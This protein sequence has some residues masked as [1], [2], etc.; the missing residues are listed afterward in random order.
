[1]AVKYSL[2]QFLKSYIAA[3]DKAVCMYSQKQIDDAKYDKPCCSYENQIK[4]G[5]FLK[6]CLENIDCFS[7][8]EQDKL[9]SVS[10]RFSQNCGGCVV[11]DAELAAFKLTPKGKELIEEFL[12][13]DVKKY[14]NKSGVSDGVII[15]RVNTYVTEL[16]AAGLWSKFYAIY[17]FLGGTASTSSY[18][19]KDADYYQ[20]SWAGGMSYGTLGVDFNGTSGFGDTNFDFS[21]ISSSIENIHISFYTADANGGLANIPMGVGSTAADDRIRIA[22]DAGTNNYYADFWSNAS[23][24]GRVLVSGLGAPGGHYLATRLDDADARVYLDGVLQASNTSTTDVSDVPSDTFYIGA[25]NVAGVASGFT[26]KTFGLSTIGMHLTAGEVTSF[27]T[28]TDKFLTS[29]GR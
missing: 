27:Q 7:D 12:D 21:A 26:T 2:D 24:V 22:F 18:N 17:P 20:V 5:L 16:K 6:F 11:T 1:V 13:V 25:A 8:E 29:L 9:I 14:K 4:K 15:G 10:N 28:I 23:I 19:L 3:A